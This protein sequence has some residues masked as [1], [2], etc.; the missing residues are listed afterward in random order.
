[1]TFTLCPTMRTVEPTFSLCEVAYPESST[2]T[3]EF[4]SELLSDRPEVIVPALSGPSGRREVSTPSTLNEF[5]VGR[6]LPLPGFPRFRG[7]VIEL[8]L[9]TSPPAAA[10]TSFSFVTAATF[11][12]A[13]GL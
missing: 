6:G 7:I 13:I 10:L 8:S 2:A 1:M 5:G 3:S 4:A 11:D 9:R 12:W